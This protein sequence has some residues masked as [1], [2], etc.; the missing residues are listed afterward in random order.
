MHQ[1]LCVPHFS[2]DRVVL[3]LFLRFHSSKHH[4]NNY[5]WHWMGLFHQTLK[6]RFGLFKF[7]FKEKFF[8]LF[9]VLRHHAARQPQGKQAGYVF[10][11]IIY[12]Q[13]LYYSKFKN[14]IFIGI[15]P[16]YFILFYEIFHKSFFSCIF[17]P[18]F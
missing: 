7:S 15:M 12:L 4:T 18:D 9:E 1:S 16:L 13:Y 5:N 10:L 8:S 14:T 11:R 6:H 2:P 3:Q 17:V